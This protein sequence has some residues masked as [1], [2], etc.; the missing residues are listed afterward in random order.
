MARLGSGSQSLF[1]QHI[2][3]NSGSPRLSPTGEIKTLF[4]LVIAKRVAGQK[5]V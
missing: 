5:K 4:I 2:C 1:T 3:F